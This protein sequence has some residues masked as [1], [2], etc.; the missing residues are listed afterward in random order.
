VGVYIGLGV[1]EGVEK[2]QQDITASILDVNASMM[3]AFSQA[4]TGVWSGMQANVRHLFDQMV[5]GMAESMEMGYEMVMVKWNDISSGSLARVNNMVNVVTLGFSKLGGAVSSSLQSVQA[6]AQSFNWAGI[7]RNMVSGITQGV[8]A[9]ATQLPDLCRD[10]RAL[11]PH[12][13]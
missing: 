13:P 3:E 5:N 1:A 2:S 10:W 6:I 4:V 7:G 9:A 11:L 8:N 12:T